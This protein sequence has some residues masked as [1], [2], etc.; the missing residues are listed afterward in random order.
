MTDQPDDRSALA[1]ATAWAS[2]ATTVALEMTLPALAGHWL[3]GRWGTRPLFVLLGA[4]LG[5]AIGLMHLLRMSA[6]QRKRRDADD[7]RAE[8]WRE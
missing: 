3:D 4:M 1:V 6:K 2:L 7:D 8:A 5:L